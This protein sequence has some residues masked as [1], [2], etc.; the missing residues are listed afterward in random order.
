[1]SRPT[2]ILPAE[3]AL[4]RFAECARRMLDP[5]TSEPLRRE[6]ESQLLRLLPVVRALG[7]FEL[8]DVRDRALAALLRDEMAVHDGL[9][10][11]A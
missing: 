10:A 5:A 6:L 2:H 11:A 9:S 1:M 4:P 7:L 3:Q 8:F